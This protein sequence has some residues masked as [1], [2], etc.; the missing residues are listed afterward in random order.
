MRPR[1]AAK[2]VSAGD[3]VDD[4]ASTGGFTAGVKEKAVCAGLLA[5]FDGAALAG[6]VL[7]GAKLKPEDPEFVDAAGACAPNAKP[8]KGLG[9]AAGAA[10]DPNAGVPKPLLVDVGANG[11]GEE[12]AAAPNAKPAPNGEGFCNG[13]EVFRVSWWWI[14]LQSN[15][16]HAYRCSFGSW[17]RRRRCGRAFPSG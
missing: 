13:F 4:G 12:L 14:A 11:L 10:A 9:L 2:Y 15:G 7:A 6:A 17:R 8:A 3:A 1:N 16:S 5:S